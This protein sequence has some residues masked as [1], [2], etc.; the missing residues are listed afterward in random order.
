MSEFVAAQA[1]VLMVPSLGKGANSF[2]TKLR[3]QLEKVRAS[4]DVEV[5]ADTAKMVAE[6]TATKKALEKDAVVVPVHYRTSRQSKS[7]LDKLKQ[8]LSEV[9]D[10][11]DKVSDKFRRSLVL[12]LQVAGMSQIRALIPLLGAVNAS[13]VQLA[14]SALLLPG[15]LAGVGT[16]LLTTVLGVKGLGDAFKAQAKASKDSVEASRQ[17]RDANNAV[18][19]STRDLNYAI[20]DAKRNL[21]DLNDQLRDAP[22]DE[23]EAMMNLQEAMAEMA[24]TSGKTAF[25]RQ[26]DALRVEKSEASLAETR[27]RNVR[28]QQDVNEANKKGIAGND[29]VVAATERLT[30]A[31]EA[32]TDHKGS[33]QDLADAMA[34]LSPNAQAF[35]TQVRALG[36]V[37]SDLRKSVQ[38]RLFDHLGEDLTSLSAITLPNVEGGLQRVAA[39][40]NGN[41]RTAMASLGS[42]SSQGFLSRIFGNTADAQAMFDRAINPLIDSFLRLGAVG[43]DY[44][45]RLSDGFGD[46]MAR[47]DRFIARAEADGSLDKWINNGIDALKQLGNS[48]VNVASIMNSVADAFTNSGGKTFGQW[49]QDNTKRL[50]DFLK[51]P[52]GQQK[53]TKFFVDARTEFAKWEPVLKTIPGIIKN[54]A[55]AGRD[56]ANGML[57]FLNTIGP[58]LRDHPGLVNTIFTA[59]MSWKSISPIVSGINLMLDNDS[60]MVGAAK[61][62]AKAVGTASKGGYAS[63]GLSG[64]LSG[65]AT[66]V[67][68]G[69]VVMLGLTAVTSYLAYEYLQA[70]QDAADAAQHHANM[71]SQLRTELDSLTGS[72]TQK[73]LIDGLNKLKGWTD[74]N[75]RDGQA[76]DVPKE[77]EGLIGREL[78]NGALDPTN[79][80]ARDQADAKLREIV[81]QGVS[82][83]NSL[84][85]DGTLSAQMKSGNFSADDLVSALM[86]DQA[87]I[88]RFKKLGGPGGPGYTLS[89]IKYG[90]KG[91]LPFGLDDKPGLSERARNALDVNKAI[92]EHTDNAL[93]VGSDIR[94]Q[95]QSITGPARIIPGKPN[96]FSDLGI[97]HVQWDTDL[98]G[99]AA[100]EVNQSPSESLIEDI[101]KN[102]GTVE[103]LAGGNGA[104]IHL[105]PDRAKLYVEKGFAAGG[106]QAGPGTG[107][108]D[109]ILAKVSNGEFISRAQSVRKYGPEFY[110]ALNRGLIDPLDLPGFAGGG[111]FGSGFRLGPD[112]A[113]PDV[114]DVPSLFDP[115]GSGPSQAGGTQLGPWVVPQGVFD[116]SRTLGPLGP[117][118]GSSDPP[119]LPGALPGVPASG[120]LAGSAAAGVKAAKPSAPWAP[121]ADSSSSSAWSPEQHLSDTATSPGPGNDQGFGG[122]A[123]TADPGETKNMFGLT[124]SD[125]DPLGLSGLPDNLQPVSILDQIGEVLLSAVLG[126]FGIDPTYFNIGKRIFT[127]VTGTGKNG[128]KRKGKGEPTDEVDGVNGIIANHKGQMDAE[129]P[130]FVGTLSS[131]AGAPDHAG[132]AGGLKQNAR[133]LRNELFAKYPMLKDIGG[134]RQDALPEHPS[135]RALDIMIPKWDSP[136]GAALG[137]QIL[138][139]VMSQPDFYG[140]IWRGKSYGYGN[141]GPMPYTQGGNDPTQGHYNHVHVWLKEVA[142]NAAKYANGGLLSGDGTGR[143]DSM[144]AR[145]SNGE[146]ITRAASVAK[147]GRGFFDAINAGAIDPALLPRFADGTP[148]LLPLGI[149]SAATAAPPVSTPM[150]NTDQTGLGQPQA[151]AGG[152]DLA[153]LGGSAK[154]GAMGPDGGANPRGQLGAAP[155][156]MDHNN[157]A[158]SKGIKGAWSTIGSLAAQAASLAVA[159]ASGGAGGLG[160]GAAG[161]GIQAAAEMGGQWASGAMNILSSLLVGTAPGSGGTTQNA[162]GA[163]VLPQGPPQSQQGGPAIVNNYGDIHTADYSEFHRGQER[164][165]AQQVGPGLPMR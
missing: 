44:L 136:E 26:K 106:L 98:S 8:N 108:S 135:G 49:L 56:W 85:N 144:L 100:I 23:A 19:D 38:D 54:I 117:N 140:A 132:G 158:L 120:G 114:P 99:G 93:S 51:G 133:T 139:D 91:G 97:R 151:S 67:S 80:G 102:G 143:S 111:L 92:N 94:A 165:L 96:P 123:T 162:Y 95:N 88:E 13:I 9:G 146:F 15:I 113:P 71:V 125:G 159:G 17:Q 156:N 61:R 45:P 149:G 163:P 59:Y 28:L 46:V 83:P 152:V 68:P 32:A 150:A 157:P 52:E 104:I 12:N 129:M 18:R 48:L 20:R 84:A 145:V 58:L 72:L 40:I 7:D 74:V 10:N 11:F 137:D 76:R 41:L 31:L 161:S 47:F 116:A 154:P 57:P 5:K 6:V 160:G 112:I 128:K 60:G 82:D 142:Q 69:G 90:H 29:Q 124:P 119:R 35:V 24:D 109:S 55:S 70:Q 42:D 141:S 164:M 16:S 2:Q 118:P 87:Q 75:E 147:Y 101:K 73:G 103:P 36:D 121:A 78:L 62:A 34:K 77:A 64:A 21:E 14:Q 53:L 50:A 3:T 138:Q 122:A 126:F 148:P 4:V 39:A 22:L 127:G 43:S 153:G 81:K 27:K 30:K 79:Q 89:D 65:L 63:G 134:F 105:D 155:T 33:V 110:D 130:G 1:S 86:G 66:L 107:T 25:Q 37:W 131:F 115:P